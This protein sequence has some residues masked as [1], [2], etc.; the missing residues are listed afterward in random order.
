[1]KF[2]EAI[3]EPE[4]RDVYRFWLAKRPAGG[5]P[6]KRNINPAEMPPAILPRLSMYRSEP[7]GRIRITLAGTEIVA[8]F[9]REETGLCL[10]EVIPEHCRTQRLGMIRKALENRAPL[11]FSG[12]T[13]FSTMEQRPIA[14]L[15]LP[16]SSDGARADHLLGAIVVGPI[17][18]VFRDVD[19]REIPD[20][21]SSI[22]YAPLEEI[23]ASLSGG[24]GPAAPA[25]SPHNPLA[26]CAPT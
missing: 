6:L 13:V 1:M 26:S 19:R 8:I 25:A 14:R 3:K 21:L 7:D 20:N 12:K 22:R 18:R 17:L 24:G 5:I 15:M 9:R 16:L 4:L 11:Y 23:D 10:D 2:L